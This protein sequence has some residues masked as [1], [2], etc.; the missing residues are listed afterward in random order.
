MMHACIDRRVGA[1]ELMGKLPQARPEGDEPVRPVYPAEVGEVPPIVERLC[2]VLH[3]LPKRR[4]S[5][6]CQ[7]QPGVILTSECVRNLSG[8]LADGAVVLSDANVDACEN[9]MKSAHEGCDWVGPHPPGVP[10][11]CLGLLRGAR[12]AND[13]CRS[14]LEC[15]HGLRCLGSGPTERGRCGKPA[16]NGLLCNTAV[17][18]LAVYV[19]QDD[20]ERRHPACADGFCDRNRCAEKIR[21]GG[22]CKANNQCLLGRCAE[23]R[24]I[25]E[26]T[27]DVGEPCLG[28]DCIEGTRC[29]EG[30][31][32]ESK[33]LGSDCT[34]SAECK[35]AC[36]ENKCNLGCDDAPLLKKLIP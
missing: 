7:R 22:A 31:C 13:V 9:A 33:P 27:A 15:Q 6:C 29:V 17:D 30:K 28:G 4:K 18:T 20:F 11:A 19:R 23:G 34:S 21:V 12:K 16:S 24:C 25:D 32:A 3:G 5:E 10:E 8:A 14:S 36:V 26:P 35:A 1:L 2:D